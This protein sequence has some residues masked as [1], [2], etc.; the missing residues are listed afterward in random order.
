[1]NYSIIF[2]IVGLFLLSGCKNPALDTIVPTNSNQV[3]TIMPKVKLLSKPEQ[4]VFSMYMIQHELDG[5][6]IPPNT[7]IEE[8]LIEEA[9]FIQLHCSANK[10]PERSTVCPNQQTAN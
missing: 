10:K 4:I 8:A 2:A 5:R 7:R 1:M 9:H 3:E 6:P